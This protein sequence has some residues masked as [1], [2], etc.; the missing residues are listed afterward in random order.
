MDV[1]QQATLLELAKLLLE[2][3]QTVLQSYSPKGCCGSGSKPDWVWKDSASY[4]IG[5]LLELNESWI[6]TEVS[7]V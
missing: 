3:K 7:H 5:R 2:H 6:Q 4:K 1:K